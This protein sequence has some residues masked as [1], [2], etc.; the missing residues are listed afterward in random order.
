M[1]KSALLLHC[2]ARE[3]SRAQLD[4]IS[5]NTPPATRTFVP[6]SHST[7]LDT[8]I[9]TMAESGFHA[10]SVRIGVARGDH[11]LFATVQTGSDLDGNQTTL[12]VAVVNSTD[13]S[14]PMKMIAG[15][16]VFCCDNLS[17]RSD[18]MAPVR[19]KHSRHGLERFRESVGLAV[20]QLDAFKE[21]E[22][23]RIRVFREAQVSDTV[24]E[25]V[26]LRAFDKGVLSHRLLPTAINE[27]RA[28][29]FDDFL[30]RTLWSL[31]NAITTTL[32]PVRKTNPQRFCAL[33][34]S[35]QSLLSEITGLP[36][37][38]VHAA[39]SA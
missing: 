8:V 6:V 30:P 21:V 31:E 28:P 26:L 14:L 33:S 1:S 27:W 19:K 22:S 38:E 16:N 37:Q 18:L 2:G 32:G 39:M 5:Q 9:Q 20:K 24:A 17:L 10:R 25:S 13:K 29:T 11:R 36:A 35:L 23:R 34:L 15:A 3:V 7:A 4:E 12:S